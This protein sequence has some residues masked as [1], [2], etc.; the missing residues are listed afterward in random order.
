MTIRAA[1]VH[2]N[3]IARDWRAL[4]AF[5]SEVLGCTPLPPERDLSGEWLDRATG[6]SGAH[7]RGAHLRLPGY[8]DNGP[9]LELFQ[10]DEQRAPAEKAPNRPGLGHI[11]FAVDDVRAACAAIVAAGGGMLGKVVTV[12][13]SGAGTIEFA[14]ATDPEGNAIEVQRWI[15]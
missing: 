13:V 5:Y 7:I 2:V 4:A 10:Y 11:A 8:G 3:L 9:T 6:L 12:E 1:F 15:A 14:Y